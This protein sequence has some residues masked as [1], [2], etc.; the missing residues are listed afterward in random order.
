MEKDL[1]NVYANPF[2]KKINNVQEIFYGNKIQAE[3][4]INLKEI[5]TKI[6]QIFNSF[7]HVY[8]SQVLITDENGVQE[9]TIVGKTNN[10]LLTID[11]KLIKINTI[12][13]IKKVK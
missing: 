4:K 1:P 9:Y 7:N 6:N 11:G 10:N 3:K 2:D 12:I 13:D 5:M 8:K